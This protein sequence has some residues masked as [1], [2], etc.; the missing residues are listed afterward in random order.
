MITQIVPGL[1]H[2][3]VIGLVGTH[4][5]WRG[6]LWRQDTGRDCKEQDVTPAYSVFFPPISNDEGSPLSGA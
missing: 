2:G 1:F 4:P 5:G 3:A 6:E